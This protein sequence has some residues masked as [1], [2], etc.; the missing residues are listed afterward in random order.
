MSVDGHL[1][2]SGNLDVAGNM[3]Y[4]P[5]VSLRLNANVITLNNG[6]VASANI[7][8]TR[9]SGATGLHTFTFPAHPTGIDYL[10]FAQAYTAGTATAFFTCTAS[11][12]FITAFSVWCRTAANA[13]VDGNFY[14]YT[15]P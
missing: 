7:A 15:V 11:H 3:L 13:I 1:T 9:T 8:I 5:Y 12:S 2:V 4:K 6:Q 10:V 14:V